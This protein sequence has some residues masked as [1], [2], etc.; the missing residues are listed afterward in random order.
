MRY[1]IEK[2][3]TG[4]VD[5]LGEIEH[6]TIPLHTEQKQAAPADQLLNQWIVSI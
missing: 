1:P 3:V 5:Q 4:N 6:L 2:S